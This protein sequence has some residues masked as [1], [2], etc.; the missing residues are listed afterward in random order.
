MESFQAKYGNSGT[1]VHCLCLIHPIDPRGRKVGGIE[2][3]IRL[4]LRHAPANWRLLLVG[5]DGYGDCSLG[6]TTNI[7]IDGRSVEFLPV[8]HFSES[9]IHRA[10]TRL[11]RSITVRFG[12]GL[13]QNL[14]RVRRA[15]GCGPATIELQRFEFALVPML[16]RRP[17]IQII[18]GEGSKHDK[19]DSLIK[20]YWF[21]HRT[22]EEIAVRAARAI[23]CVNP[24]IEAKIKRKL[25]HRPSSV[26]FMPVAVDTAIFEQAPFDHHE[27]IFRV[28]FAGRLDEFKDPPTMFR[29]LRAV[30]ERL[31]GRFE[32][33]YIGTS[34]PFRYA[35]FAE[36][37]PF[38]VRHGHCT[39][40][41]VA[42]ISAQCHAGIL[43][44]L[45]EGMPCY[46]LELLAVGRPVAAIR[47]PQ[48]D[49]VIEEGVSGSLVERRANDAT[50]IHEL[51]DRLVM[52]WMAIER[53]ELDP[54][55][56]R[57][58]VEPFST[59]SLLG[60][61]FALH[62]QVWRASRCLNG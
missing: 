55:R 50:T 38:T 40:A 52:I 4:L 9:E 59:A 8:I 49:L 12:V 61:H 2:T 44:S 22:M 62:E 15:V 47:L 17:A 41:E 23:V 13:L 45:F 42:A 1:G 32:F 34:D 48:Y 6:E 14:L 53:D 7:F 39:A 46:L 3:H 27:G 11:Y 10:A 37:E 33:H 26:G 21:V 5:V 28:V 29:T 51:A 24:N 56:I 36:I 20:K 57:A 43:T 30:H 19:M 60:Q 58:K 31:G 35:E 16:L 25:P 54:R 18:H